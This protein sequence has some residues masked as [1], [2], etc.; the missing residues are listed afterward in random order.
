VVVC[1]LRQGGGIKAKV[2]EAL[3]RGK[4]IVTTP[5]GAQGFGSAAPRAMRIA[6][7]PRAIAAEVIDLLRRGDRRR[8]LE[9]RASQLASRLPTW[10]QAAE[11]LLG[12][13]REL[14]A[15]EAV[16]RR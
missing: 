6:D 3:A 10:D 15:R 1:P 4:A 2:V 11:A 5:V 12:C 14:L 16:A 9:A 7:T 13:Y 8:E